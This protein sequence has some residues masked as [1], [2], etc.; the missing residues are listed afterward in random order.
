MRGIFRRYKSAFKTKPTNYLFAVF[1]DKSHIY[2]RRQRKDDPE[3]EGLGVC[4]YVL[5]N[6]FI[7]IEEPE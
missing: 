5:N 6:S 3:Q 4:D 1:Q 7:Y 2:Y